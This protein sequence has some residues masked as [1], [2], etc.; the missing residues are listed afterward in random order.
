[1]GDGIDY[2][3]DQIIKQAR[4]LIPECVTVI[5]K[6]SQGEELKNCYRLR[7]SDTLAA[8]KILICLANGD[9]V[10][11][12]LN[13]LNRI[14]KLPYRLSENR[15][16]EEERENLMARL[17][18]SNPDFVEGL[19]RE[20]LSLEDVS[21]MLDKR[22]QIIFSLLEEPERRFNQILQ[23]TFKD[24]GLSFQEFLNCP[25]ESWDEIVTISK[26]VESSYKAE[27]DSIAAKD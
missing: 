11:L 12:G 15:A 8:A 27:E 21:G 4:T 1:M 24:H 18:E 13:D 6:I 5:S 2:F 25:K 3:Q 10:R 19:K 26:R 16:A 22:K 14:E 20:H 23:L 9:D 17:E 7:V